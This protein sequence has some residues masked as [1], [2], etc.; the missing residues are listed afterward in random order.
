MPYLIDGHN[1]I[2]KIPG[3]SL[4]EIDDEL[5]LIQWL[6]RFSQHTGKRLE[7]FFDNAPA[8]QSGTRDYGSVRVHFVRQGE[9]ADAAIQRRLHQLGRSARN[10]TVVS[11]DR[12]VQAGA[13]A[14]HARVIPSSDFAHGL[15]PAHEGEPVN[16][17]TDPDVSLSQDDVQNWLD[18]FGTEAN[19]G[20][21]PD[22]K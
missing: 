6:Q 7:V 13:R 5:C 17:E 14:L 16:L 4:K 21:F 22:E 15:D 2:P 12:G 18:F 11:S 9:T 1:L 3:L 8:G 10:W 19:A 20:K